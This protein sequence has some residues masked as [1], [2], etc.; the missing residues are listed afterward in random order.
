MN[1]TKEMAEKNEIKQIRISIP[2][3]KKIKQLNKDDIKKMGRFVSIGETIERI[4]L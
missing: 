1:E 4:V 3:H 2:C